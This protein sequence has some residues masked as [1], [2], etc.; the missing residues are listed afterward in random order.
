MHYPVSSSTYGAI[1]FI[2]KGM[3]LM[4]KAL[5]GVIGLPL[6][7]SNED[8]MPVGG[9][10]AF[11]SFVG[12]KSTLLSSNSITSSSLTSNHSNVTL[13]RLAL[14]HRVTET[15]K[16]LRHFEL[17]NFIPYIDFTPGQSKPLSLLH[18]LSTTRSSTPE[19]EPYDGL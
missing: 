4:A 14:N 18:L 16:W 6:N 8:P 11:F 9:A 10:N 19:F 3:P 15:R 5:T 12:A 2:L 17:C 7:H 1:S 13:G